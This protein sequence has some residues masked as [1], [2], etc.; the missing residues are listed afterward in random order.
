MNQNNM[1]RLAMVLQDRAATT[2]DKYICK[3]IESVLFY[4]DEQKLSAEN[5]C[6][7]ISEQ[8]GLLFDPHEIVVAVRKKE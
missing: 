3:L 4:S 6:A 1:L 5:I 8:Y 7:I 2:L